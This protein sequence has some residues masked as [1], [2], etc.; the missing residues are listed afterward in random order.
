MME[1][2]ALLGLTE[3]EAEAVLSAQEFPWVFGRC[4]PRRERPQ[5]CLQR[6]IRV[7]QLDDGT[8]EV[9]LSGFLDF[10]RGGDGR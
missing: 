8:V 10:P 6:V 2:K 5:D 4:E 1:L 9:T 7:R 3:A